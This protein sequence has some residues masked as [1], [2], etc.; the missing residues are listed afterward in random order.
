MTRDMASNG[1]HVRERTDRAGP[2]IT[3]V[4]VPT[5]DV[6]SETAI[7]TAWH[8]ADR[9][10]VEAGDL[11]AEVE[12]SKAV[13]DVVAPDSGYLLRRAREG[14]EIRLAE[15][16]AYLFESPDALHDHAASLAEAAA[17]AALATV[18]GPRATAPAIRRAEE[19]GV[20][21]GSVGARDLIT[22]KMVEA[23]ARD[24]PGPPVPPDLPEPLG[25][26]SGVERV[27]LIGAGLGATQVVGI[28]A[29]TSQKAVAIVDDDRARWGGET[30][31]VPVVGGTEQLSQL[32][33]R[34]CF[35]S[36]VIC[37]GTSVPARTRFREICGEL[38]IPLANAIDL[39]A[40]IAADVELGQGNVICAFCHFGV[41]TRIG[42]NNFLSANNSFDH[43]NVLG[44]D[45]ATGPGCMT[46]GVVTIGDRARLGTG[47][48]VEP[49]VTI[50]E[51]VQVAS[52]AV[53]V[54]SV[55]PEHAVKRRVVTTSVVPIRRVR[56]P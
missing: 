26:P 22:V 47:I 14:E 40:L 21:L 15:A 51:G 27:A 31:G 23:A 33:A 1:S 46:S 3:P 18:D 52:G 2:G 24:R 19:L 54:S 41:G 45:I 7:V 11:L 53:I 37:I 38:D 13:V 49:H 30:A 43:H 17:H 16:I 9:T 6:N 5:T 29:G 8:V 25:A 12:T 39:T 48:F 35:D 44:N 32:H 34:G 10:L 36:A 55:P 56:E 4:M 28:F 20:E 50:G 42:D